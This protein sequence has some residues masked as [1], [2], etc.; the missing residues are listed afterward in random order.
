MPTLNM[1]I[2]KFNLLHIWDRVLLKMPGLNSK[3][4]AQAFGH[5]N[6]NT[7]Y[8]II[9]TFPLKLNNASFPSHLLTGSEHVHRT[10]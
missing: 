7:P 6:S 2:S 8:Q 3:R 10:S 5:A 4:H 9:P 1:N